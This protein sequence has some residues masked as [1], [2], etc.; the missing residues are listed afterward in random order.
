MTFHQ[1]D[2]ERVIVDFVEYCYC[3]RGSD[4]LYCFRRSFLLC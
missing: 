4:G 3:S 2:E 1:F